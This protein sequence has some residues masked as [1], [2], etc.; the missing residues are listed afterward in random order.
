MRHWVFVITLKLEFTM[1][2]LCIVFENFKASRYFFFTFW[3]LLFFLWI[4]LIWFAFLLFL[5]L[6]LFNSLVSLN[7]GLIVF[8]KSRMFLPKHSHIVLHY[9]LRHP[10]NLL[11]DLIQ[12]LLRSFSFFFN[13]FFPFP[14]LLNQIFFQLV[15]SRLE[16]S[17]VAFYLFRICG[18]IIQKIV[19]FIWNSTT[20]R[21]Y[22]VNFGIL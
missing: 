17:K 14:D 20:Y 13:S 2:D 19:K 21:F 3:S 12:C 22:D 10:L 9:L 6:L 5:R 1:L 15:D 18:K 11:S 8:M 4:F 16:W 7:I